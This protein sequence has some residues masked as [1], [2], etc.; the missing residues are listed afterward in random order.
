MDPLLGFFASTF[1][2][3]ISF[4]AFD[5]MEIS[6]FPFFKACHIIEYFSCAS[7]PLILTFACLYAARNLI[8]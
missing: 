8:R 2:C 5:F 1:H 3:C 6:S 4:S 7:C